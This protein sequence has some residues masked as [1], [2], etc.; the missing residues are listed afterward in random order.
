[1]KIITILIL[2]YYKIIKLVFANI[3]SINIKNVYHKKKLI[4]IIFLLF[5][6]V[7]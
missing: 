1:M 6:N 7:Y 3:I 5:L 2:N 4:Y